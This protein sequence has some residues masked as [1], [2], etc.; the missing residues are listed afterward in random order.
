MRPFRREGGGGGGARSCFEG[1]F[2]REVARELA[3]IALAMEFMV[4]KELTDVMEAEVRRWRWEAAVVRCGGGVGRLSVAETKES[5]D[6]ESSLP[7]G[8][9]VTPGSLGSKLAA[10]GKRV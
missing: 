8:S 1:E 6:E 3:T 5:S 4:L 9:F 7:F 2:A 10:A